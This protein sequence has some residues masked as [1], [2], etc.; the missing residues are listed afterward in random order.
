MN[1]STEK[2][3][4]QESLIIFLRQ[5]L[6]E[7]ICSALDDDDITEIMVNPDGS[8]WLESRQKGK[9][10]A[11]ILDEQMADNF[12]MQLASYR[13]IFINAD[14][15]RISTTLPFN[16]ERIEATIRP[17]S[18]RAA[19]S[20]RKHSKEVYSLSDY[21]DKG[22]FKKEHVKA[23]QD[24]IRYRKNILVSGGPGSGKTTLANAIIKEM[25]QICDKTERI[26]ILEDTAELQ[27]EMPNQYP[28]TTD[29]NISMTEL[30]QSA[31]RL[32]PDRIFVGEVRDKAALDLLKAWNT[33]TPGGIATI[34]SNAGV[35]AALIRLLYLAQEAQVPPPYNLIA[36]TVNIIIHIS[37]DPAHQAGRVVKDIAEL[38]GYE[39]G[40]FIFE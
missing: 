37:F 14:N 2:Q 13:G 40:K 33:G 32:R 19:F 16:N 1:E 36:E 21:V 4:Q 6:G 35:E 3:K 11:G 34:H 23:I 27:C 22:I 20:I 38:K 15:P 10:H 26:I 12:L 39:N 29:K 25:Y 5:A 31:M 17:I 28:M 24:A 9:Y 30:L 18:T 7:T 8:L